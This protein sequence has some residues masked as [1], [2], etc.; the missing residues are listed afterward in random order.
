MRKIKHINKY[1][2]SKVID[3]CLSRKRDN[4]LKKN[5]TDNK[6]FILKEYRFFYKMLDDK[7]FIMSTNVYL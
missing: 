1:K 2:L 6:Y 7:S 4:V 3:E 5:V